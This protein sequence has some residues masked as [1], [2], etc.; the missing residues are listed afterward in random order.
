M[1]LLLLLLPGNIAI[2]CTVFIDDLFK[3][4]LFVCMSVYYKMLYILFMR[5]FYC[6]LNSR[7]LHTIFFLHPFSLC[8]S[9]SLSLSLCFAF[10]LSLLF[11][12]FC[13]MHTNMLLVIC[14]FFS[15]S[16]VYFVFF[17]YFVMLFSHSPHFCNDADVDIDSFDSSTQ[18]IQL[19]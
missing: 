17:F 10:S 3:L 11:Y 13:V 5:F 2:V 7:L 8:L 19:L 6:Q 18:T 14:F 1:R 12:C 16:L 4:L 9:L 15:L